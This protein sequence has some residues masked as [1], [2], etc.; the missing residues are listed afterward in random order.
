[1][2]FMS[3]RSA[4]EGKDAIA[5]GLDDEAL[6]TMD[7]VHHELQSRIDEVPGRFG[8]EVFNERGGVLDIGKEGGDG[9]ALAIVCAP[10]FQRGLLSADALGQV[11]RGVA[12]GGLGLSGS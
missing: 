8:I 9:L 10:R 5:G 7:R 1:M 12:S 6:I 4:E 2:V 3:N 11:W